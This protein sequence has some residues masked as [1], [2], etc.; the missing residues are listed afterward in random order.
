[1]SDFNFDSF[2]NEL[3]T[4]TAPKASNFKEKVDKSERLTKVIM[5]IPG[6]QGSIYMIPVSS[7]SG[8][9]ATV[10]SDVKEVKFAMGEDGDTYERWV[11]LLPRSFYNFAVGGKEELLYN[12]IIS[13]HQ[14][15]KTA[16]FDWKKVKV[17][18]YFLI[19]GYALKHKNEGNEIVNENNPCLFVFDNNRMTS[20][21]QAEI[22]SKMELVGHHNW[23]ADWFN[24]NAT[25]RTKLMTMNYTK[26]GQG[27]AAV[28]TSTV[29]LATINEDHFG[30]TGS[31]L[32]VDIPEKSMK[33]FGDPINDFMATDN[34]DGRFD[35]DYHLRV[36]D[37]MMAALG[38]ANAVIPQGIVAGAPQVVAQPQV[39]QVAQPQAVVATPEVAQAVT[40]PVSTPAVDPNAPPF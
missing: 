22:K 17:R 39:A 11:K 1:M 13:L 36:K 21:F 5:L 6:N 38:H 4:V 12:E 23:M 29:S 37:K 16:G 2:L 8:S 10:I 33:V 30:L 25:G 7:A 40:P 27:T 9:P 31:K 26:A 20:A 35:Y 15:M 19:Y 3:Q 18:N 34:V 24:T 28:W 32:A 14:A